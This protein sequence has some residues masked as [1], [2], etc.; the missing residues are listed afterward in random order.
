MTFAVSATAA[1]GQYEIAPQALGSALKQFAQQANVQLL[2]TPDMV[3][4][5]RTQGVYGVF[6]PERALDILL[7]R[8]G[9]TFKYTDEDTVIVHR[10]GTPVPGKQ[11]LLRHGKGR[12]TMGPVYLAQ[13]GGTVAPAVSGGEAIVVE[14]DEGPL[15]EIIVTAQKREQ[16]LMDVPLTITAYT[17]QFL[18]DMGIEHFADLSY[19]VP[20]LAVQEQSPVRPSFNIRGISSGSTSSRDVPRLSVF[21]D[22]I[23][24]SRN[25]SGI[26]DMFDMERIEVLKGPQSTLYG[27]GSSTGAIMM[28]TAKPQAE[29]EGSVQVAMGNYNERKIRGHMTGAILGDKLLGRVMFNYRKRD[30]F[31]KNI[32]GTRESQNP[33]ESGKGTTLS[34]VESFATRMS[35]RYLPN[36][37]TTVDLIF[38]WQHD[39]PPGVAFKAA[40]ANPTGGDGSPFTF[41]ELGPNGDTFGIDKKAWGLHFLVDY[42]I[43]DEWSANLISG[44]RT[45]DGFS[46]WD[47]DGFAARA[48]EFHS[49]EEGKAYSG[50]LRFNYDSGGKLRGFFGANYTRERNLDTFNMGYDEGHFAIMFYKLIGI[51]GL[52]DIPFEVNGVPS[53]IDESP[54]GLGTMRPWLEMLA[55]GTGRFDVYSFYADATY[56]ILDN[57][58][59]SAGIRYIREKKG[60][61]TF[62][63]NVASRIIPTTPLITNTNGISGGSGIDGVGTLSFDDIMPRFNLSYR[64]NEDLMTYAIVSKGRRS[65]VVSPTIGLASGG[66]AAYTDA[67]F[68]VITMTNIAAEILWNYE[69]G[70]K[71]EFFDNRVAVDLAYYH[72]TYS[73]FRTNQFD[74]ATGRFQALNAGS[75]TADGVEFSLR[76]APTQGLT[77]FL[78]GAYTDTAFDAVGKGGEVQQ[79][80]GN[81]FRLSSKYTASAGFSYTAPL[82]DLGDGLVS[83]D[84]NF[85]SRHFFQDDNQADLVQNKVHLV[86]AKV[87]VENFAGGEWYASFVVSNLFDK[88]FIIDAGNIGNIFGI[89]TFITGPRRVYGFE[90]GRKF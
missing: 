74:P 87:G 71:A 16:R 53:R 42:E 7:E 58:D 52:K 18:D 20:G 78:N 24:A 5:I 65:E 34:G 11:S 54:M 35:L 45:F 13:A 76:G 62:G 64:W 26:I 36:D 73:N 21:L 43:N 39:T 47:S 49:D 17:G 86:N 44:Y 40:A 19:I 88:K 72:Y 84:W 67:G 89:P 66:E 30:G 56:S 10:K 75:A 69:A 32:D 63:V 23:D 25:S 51:P 2:F 37:R 6:A 50:E 1:E 28:I 61:T 85:R 60:G 33:T 70:I 82:G 59:A 9:L 68:P 29:P 46:A 41:A 83:A 55:G 79:L 80:A 27:S 57:L 90:I 77:V 48:M 22:G 8:S 15:E 4:T 38:N 31:I 81:Q 12:N 3:G 14:E